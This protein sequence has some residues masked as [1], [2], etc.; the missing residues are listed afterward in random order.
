MKKT[1]FL[2]VG[3]AFFFCL[4]CTDQKSNENKKNKQTAAI[5]TG[6]QTP[7]N[8]LNSE[9]P[10]MKALID[11]KKWVATRTG[12]PYTNSDYVLVNGETENISI[13]FQIHKPANGLI[14]K[15]SENHAANFVNE[16]GFWGGKKGEVT[17][18][19]VDGK[20]IEGTFSFEATSTNINSGHLYKI[21]G[22]EF[23][24]KTSE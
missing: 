23:R 11:G 8:I 15:F 17:V 24:V 4:S 2:A 1:I 12:P 21:T 6:N 20:W 22:G 13:N 9:G 14:E 3:A 10:F 16:D 19:R 18:T 7:D 5:Q